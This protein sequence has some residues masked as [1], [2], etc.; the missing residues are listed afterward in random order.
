LWKAHAVLVISGFFATSKSAL[1]SQPAGDSFCTMCKCDDQFFQLNSNFM[2]ERTL[3][4]LPSAAAPGGDGGS[5][6]KSL[7][8]LR[9]LELHA[10]RPPSLLLLLFHCCGPTRAAIA[11]AVF[12]QSLPT[13]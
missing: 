3:D 9:P 11:G 12:D 13:N 1:T 4:V 5:R 2:E 8:L 7:Q 10:L 6:R